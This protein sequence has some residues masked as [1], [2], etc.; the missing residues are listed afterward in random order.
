MAWTIFYSVL[1]TIGCDER[2]TMKCKS[3]WHYTAGYGILIIIHDMVRK[4]FR[5]FL[6]DW[7]KEFWI[8]FNKLFSFELFCCAKSCR[9]LL[10]TGSGNWSDCTHIRKLIKTIHFLFNYMSVCLLHQISSEISR[11][12][13]LKVREFENGEKSNCRTRFICTY[14]VGKFILKHIFYYVY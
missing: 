12:M 1:I 11:W 8:I 7:H 2:W 4:H 6:Y 14:T 3:E 13:L 5:N 9:I 10:Q